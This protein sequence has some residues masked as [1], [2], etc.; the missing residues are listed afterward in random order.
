MTDAEWTA[1]VVRALG[2]AAPG[3]AVLWRGSSLTG[4]DVDLVVLEG[5]DEE[6]ARVLEAEGLSPMPSRPGEV[7]WRSGV[8]RE[9]VLDVW[10]SWAWPAQYPPLRGVATRATVDPEL[11][12]PVAAPH[13][14]LLCFG[15]EAV[16]GRPLEKL[17]PKAAAALEE[18]A[19]GTRVDGLARVAATLPADGPTLPVRAAVRAALGSRAGRA[20]LRARWLGTPV[21]L[22]PGRSDAGPGRLVTL[23]GL[24]G[25]GKSS[26]GLAL[27]EAL[28]AGGRPAIVTWSRVGAEHGALHV[29]AGAVRRVL[30]REM[31]ASSAVDPSVP[32]G[33]RAQ[34]TSGGAAGREGSDPVARAWAVVVAL[35]YARH[36][37]RLTRARRRGV[38]IVCDRWTAD[39]IVDLRLRYG[40]R[41]L[42][43]HALRAL[44]PRPDVAVLLDVPPEISLQ[45]KPGDQDERSLRAM[46]SLYAELARA[47]PLA[48]VDAARAPADVRAA[49]RALVAAPPGDGR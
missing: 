24:D 22:P 47:L 33:S 48:R 46:H 28:R 26:A 45:R 9:V 3:A 2:D 1:R 21:A 5:R 37:R 14:R 18:L 17:R 35:A 6:V 36:C 29:L 20:A 32:V 8:D 49:L 23:S 42:A 19:G 44:M 4:S 30:R 39:A 15:A 25:A 34:P 16:A 43:E 13:D 38:D 11:G 7:E 10:S 40:R 27:A 31:G 12:L 41:P